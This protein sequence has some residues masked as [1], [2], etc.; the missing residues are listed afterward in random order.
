MVAAA[1]FA[2]VVEVRGVPRYTPEEPQLTVVVTKER[3]L[4][5]QKFV[6]LLCADCH[7]DPSTGRLTGKPMLDLPPAFGFVASKNITKHPERGIGRWSDGQ[8]A[9]FLR[10]GVGPDGTYAPP[11]MPKLAGL[12]D[13]DLASIIA[14]L[15]SDDPRVAPSD[16]VP[17]VSRPSL[18]SKALT[19]TVM[20]PLP[21]PRAPIEAPPRTD[22]VAWG[23]YLSVAYDCFTC[24]SGDLARVDPLVPEKSFGYFGGG[25]VMRSGDGRDIRTANLTADEAT[26]IGG[27]TEDQFVRAVKAGFRPDGQ[28]LRA[29]MAPRPELEDDEVRAIYTYLRT[30]PRIANPVERGF[31]ATGE[32]AADPGA[33]AFA[34]YGCAGCHGQ[35]GVGLGGLADLRR[36]NEHFA[37]DAELRAWLDDAP[38]K[39]PGTR[40][41]GFRGRIAEPD[42]RP[43]LG[44]VRKLAVGPRSASAAGP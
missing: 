35:E 29:P 36:A 25:A 28:V 15:R 44:H 5:G 43:L 9:Y 41:P 42:Y 23:R 19:N 33:R 39:K 21:Y 3:T 12:S 24:H 38:E 10:T 4:R 8:L 16:A 14:F 11:W 30:V 32:P 13:E 31:V 22:R 17:P 20:K 6:T 26:G 1:T 27:W 37:T 2:A 18:L 34:S 40:M 7:A